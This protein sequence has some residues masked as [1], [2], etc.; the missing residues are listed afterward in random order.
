MKRN[1]K[2]TLTIVLGVISLLASSVL[3]SSKFSL[4]VKE[5][6]QNQLTALD[7][8]QQV[9]QKLGELAQKFRGLVN[10]TGANL[11][12]PLGGNFTE[13]LQGLVDSAQF[14]N[15]TH[16]LSQQISWLGIIG[17]NIKNLQEEGGSDFSSLVQKFQNLT[18][19]RRGGQ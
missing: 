7:N 2:L 1:G 14:K 5:K 8:S 17:S 13:K 9:Q 12:L 6:G 3:V 16:Q 10:N 11:S 15:L 4:A 19:S 18:S